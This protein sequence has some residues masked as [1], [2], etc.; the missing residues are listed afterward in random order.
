MCERLVRIAAGAVE[1]VVEH[2]HPLLVVVTRFRWVVHDQH[3]V[4]PAVELDPGM[5]VVEVGA[6]VGDGELVGEAVLGTDRVLGDPRDTVHVVAQRNA[7]P[8]HAGICR[9]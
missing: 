5:R 4:Q 7:V 9:Q 3:A 2:D 8:V 1:P 6:G